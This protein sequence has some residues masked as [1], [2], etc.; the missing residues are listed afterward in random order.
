[1]VIIAGVDEAGRGAVIGPLVIAGVSIDTAKER[2]LAQTGAKDSKELSPKQRAAIYK[3]IE[4]VA[5]DIV[6]LKIDAC[7]IETYRKE[8][9]NLNQLEAMKF[10]EI[11]KLLQPDQ[12]YADAP[13][14][15][16]SRFARVVGKLVGQPMEITAEHKADA[17]Y[18]VV[19]AASV[20]AKVERDRAIEQLKKRYG[21]FG[22][23]YPSNPI[24]MA[25]LRDWYAK[26]HSFPDI[27]RES[28]ATIADI[29]RE[30]GQSKLQ[31]FLG[32][33]KA[34]KPC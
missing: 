32:K 24:T 19:G 12:A 20:I 33:L 8:G 17:K 14:V 9:I 2:E 26:H 30:S 1:M 15:D 13:D 4:A 23:G 18:K 11:V 3:K 16:A 6:I 27:V 21:D 22:P 7:K 34:D 25:W 28:W 5:K 29:K 10:A 31:A